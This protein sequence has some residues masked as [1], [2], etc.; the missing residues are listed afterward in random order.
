MRAEPLTVCASRN[1]V[2]TTCRGDG[3]SSL[4]GFRIVGA[5]GGSGEMIA[6]VTKQPPEKRA[7]IDA[8]VNELMGHFG[9]HSRNLVRALGETRESKGD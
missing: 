2:T 1:S 8:A 9:A 5:S 3:C 4:I 7:E 6:E